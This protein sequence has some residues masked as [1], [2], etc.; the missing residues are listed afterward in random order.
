MRVVM[1]VHSLA[2]C[3][4]HGN[5]HFLRGIAGELGRRGHRVYS[6]EPADA[7]SVQNLIADGGVDALAAYRKAYPQLR[8]R[9]YEPAKLDLERV[10]DDADLVL[11]HEWNEPDLIAKIGK[12]R[13]GAD[14]RL[15]FHDTH[16]RAV[17]DP[18]AMQKYDLSEYDG[19]LAFGDVL[20]DL[21][22]D[23]G[24]AR[25][26][27]T[28]HE[29]AD[30]HVFRP[31]A[32]EPCEG[33]LVW[34]GNWGDDDRTH[35]LSEFLLTPAQ[36]LGL[37]GSIFGVRYPQ[38]ARDAVARS[39]LR[40]KGWLPNH[41]VPRVF[42]RHRATVHVPRRPY[43]AMLPGIPTIRIFEALACGIPLVSAPWDD[44]DNLFEAGVHYLRATN[45][46]EM[47]AHLRALLHEPGLA[48]GIAARG[49]ARILE[50]HTCAH[51]VDELLGIMNSLRETPDTRRLVS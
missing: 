15:F 7:W 37:K 12:L 44:V 38:T 19:V 39:G 34:V 23:R 22:R 45:G 50:R 35:E 14:F 27:W 42:A 2:S 11:V 24:W 10:L 25:R 16:H 5:V 46:R 8:I 28:W 4:N 18:T 48:A 49:R 40:Y 31:L 20:R 26:A 9:A 36:S 21:Y 6:Y 30:T 29:A 1:F 41:E 32:A 33:D 43:A 3:W 47:R 13:R 17:S 51:R